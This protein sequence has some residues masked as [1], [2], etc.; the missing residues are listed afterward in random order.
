[1]YT[2]RL[3]HRTDCDRE[4]VHAVLLRGRE[5]VRAVTVPFRVRVDRTTR[6]QMRWYFEDYPRDGSDVSAAAAG[7]VERQMADLGYELFA[8]IFLTHHSIDLWAAL[9]PVLSQTRVEVCFTSASGAAVPWEL[10][11]PK[12]D[13]TPLLY[14]VRS[15]VRL[16]HGDAAPIGPADPVRRS[17]RLLFVC[18]RP[19]GVDDL[20]YTSVAT[21]LTHVRRLDVL[22]PATFDQLSARLQA[23]AE[24]DDPY[25]VV[26]FDGHGEMRDE[27]GRQTNDPSEWRKGYLLFED[28]QGGARPVSGKQFGQI[29]A[30]ARVSLAVM[31]ACRSAAAEVLAESRDL[32][33]GGYSA[34]GSVAE[35]LLA[36]G[37]PA[38]VAMRYNAYV[39]T[40]S[41]FADVYYALLARGVPSG[42]AA[43]RARCSLCPDPAFRYRAPWR[44]DEVA[45]TQVEAGAGGSPAS[46][47]VPA[48]PADPHPRLDWY[49]PVVYERGEIPALGV[50]D[51]ATGE[52][53]EET[54][55]SGRGAFPGREP[56]REPWP[57]VGRDDTLFRLDR[58]FD[59]SRVVVL[60]GM[61][62]AGKSRTAVEFARW[63]RRTGGAE[64]V[65]FSA[66]T[67]ATR[68]ERLEDD[69]A[70]AL[71]PPDG[72]DRAA[73]LLGLAGQQALLWVVDGLEELFKVKDSAD[74]VITSLHWLE[75]KELVE[76]YSGAG[77]KF[78]LTSRGALGG[79][80]S[81]AKR[82][83]LLPLGEADSRVV[84]D[85][86]AP[87][88]ERDDATNEAWS[89]LVRACSGNPGMLVAA[90]DGCRDRGSLSSQRA[91]LV[92][93]ALEGGDGRRL[94]SL[95][96]RAGDRVLCPVQSA[97]VAVR[98][99]L[100]ALARFLYRHGRRSRK[101]APGADE[102]RSLALLHLFRG[103][104]DAQVLVWFAS[105]EA[106]DP[107]V[108]KKGECPV[109][110]NIFSAPGGDSAWQAWCADLK[111]GSEAG[112]LTPDR[113]GGWFKND[114]PGFFLLHPALRP[115]LQTAYRWLPAP[116]RGR[117]ARWF[118]RLVRGSR[119][120]PT[121]RSPAWREACFA[122]TTAMMSWFY[123]DRY[124]RGHREAV[125]YLARQE[126][127]MVAAVELAAV[128]RWRDPLY[129]LLF[130]FRTLY[131]D[132]GRRREWRNLLVRLLPLCLEAG[133]GKALPG[134]ADYQAEHLRTWVSELGEP[135]LSKN[136]AGPGAGRPRGGGRAADLLNEGVELANRRDRSCLEK[137]REAAAA[138]SDPADRR[139]HAALYFG[140]ACVEFEAPQEYA[141]AREA[142]LEA[143]AAPG[144][145]PPEDAATWA[146]VESRV[147]GLAWAEHE[148]RRKHHPGLADRLEEL[149]RLADQHIS[150]AMTLIPE[151]ELRRRAEIHHLAGSVKRG[152]NLPEAIDAL[153]EA[154][155][156]D[157][158]NGDRLNY[159][160]TLLK[161]AD[162]LA[163]AG[164][165]HEAKGYA[166]HAHAVLL[167]L[168]PALRPPNWK[169]LLTLAAQT[170]LKINL[171]AG[172]S[173]PPQTYEGQ[174]EMF[175]H[176]IPPH[177]SWEHRLTT[178]GEAAAPRGA[179][180]VIELHPDDLARFAACPGDNPGVL[181]QVQDGS[182]GERV[183][184]RCAAG[185]GQGPAPRLTTL[186][187]LWNLF[188]SFTAETWAAGESR[189]EGLSEICRLLATD[190]A[191]SDD[192]GKER[193]RRLYGDV[194]LTEFCDL[195]LQSR[196][197]AVA[198]A[199]LRAC[200]RDDLDDI[201]LP[202]HKGIQ[203][204]DLAGLVL[205]VL[206]PQ[207]LFDLPR[208]RQFFLTH[209]L[210]V[211]V[212]ADQ[213]RRPVALADTLYIFGLP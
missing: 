116:P 143:A 98:H 59:T 137:F 55:G 133:S 63:Y 124:Q 166:E 22:R 72:A 157:E 109:Q 93:D 37:V 127:N 80:L 79:S 173:L 77:L 17:P 45:T 136:W 179:A 96:G 138:A 111:H 187:N 115:A 81:Q 50:A 4:E 146:E 178:A 58:A 117:F 151:S 130:A 159:S 122:A 186:L 68:T 62:G 28:G 85:A 148:W 3:T 198:P 180:R 205:T 42:E 112:L 86:I 172:Y 97:I 185:D 131:H 64:T 84:F 169:D 33:T 71:A 46:G 119:P 165:Y 65:V 82:V 162:T 120:S 94:A 170:G 21:Q 89:A 206:Y 49:V 184:V 208:L 167:G 145:P 197:A 69:L 52:D 163:E 207:F 60:E 150:K 175:G 73:T 47:G 18:C 134:L 35:Q 212:V 54:A 25:Q 121:E 78:L 91:Q 140:R 7:E 200:L 126:L 142:I 6:Q 203:H 29:L 23:A 103:F 149:G 132:A 160:G 196:R 11:R 95:L 24:Q 76:R 123:A 204:R 30:E 201:L 5:Q 139:L 92:A 101:F 83:T 40:V 53:V 213:A 158:L 164:R 195:G 118:R 32:P 147:A 161:L 176:T 44:S 39:G 188:L 90:A 1:M 27:F 16:P 135:D 31:N 110:P 104:I 202:E 192:Y 183:E 100:T 61:I 141:A 191:E 56:R 51:G 34:F 15:F 12:S 114:E 36:A 168:P 2:I 70:T 210:P 20:R 194:L 211:Q 171:G 190:E 105:P 88:S 38:V 75:L 67:P 177:P 66:L 128:N 19:Q 154:A 144:G 156:C 193:V 113:P 43:T 199:R 102:P 48:A 174:V 9:E 153:R 125:D 10:M 152:R 189:A 209:V 13:A 41:R 87:P 99:E 14:L 106:E 182:P 57:F 181:S 8:K 155:R 26:H 74:V 129:F 107:D 108:L